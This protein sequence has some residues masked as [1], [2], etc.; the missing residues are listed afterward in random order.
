MLL[1]L[2]ANEL[3]PRLTPDGNCALHLFET[4]S[5][6]F[7][8]ALCTKPPSPFVGDV[9]R[10]RSGE[11]RLGEGGV[12]TCSGSSFW[13]L[14]RGTGDPSPVAVETEDMLEYRCPK[15]LS[16]KVELAL[17]GEGDLSSPTSGCELCF[18]SPGGTSGFVSVPSSFVWIE[19]WSFFPASGFS[20]AIPLVI[21]SGVSSGLV[22]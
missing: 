22:V 12:A 3:T 15:L 19:P 4:L 21:E 1:R 17:D 5:D 10:E 14:E 20:L 2:L 7:I 13:M 11:M 16:P 8:M 18:S 9:E 6:R